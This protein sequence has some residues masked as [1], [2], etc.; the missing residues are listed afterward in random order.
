MENKNLFRYKAE[1]I[2]AYDGDTIDIILDLGFKIQLKE[3]VRLYGID[4]PEMRGFEKS[5]GVIT[6]DWLREKI[7]GKTIIVETFKNDKD[8]YGKYG[9]FLANIYLPDEEK[10]L[11]DEMVELN[12]ARK[13]EY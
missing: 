4:A 11:N 8:K 2:S 9:R 13:A 6:R 12:L 7:L 5:K 1:V 10:S 3:R